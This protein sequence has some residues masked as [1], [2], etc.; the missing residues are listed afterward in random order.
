MTE[1]EAKKKTCPNMIAYSYVDHRNGGREYGYTN[2]LASVCIM[3]RWERDRYAEGYEL[4]PDHED[5]YKG[6]CG[7]GGRP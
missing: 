7:L 2:C 5:Y 3:W 1:E 6:Y 4:K